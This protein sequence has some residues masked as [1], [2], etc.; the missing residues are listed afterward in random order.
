MIQ[1]PLGVE[2][3]MMDKVRRDEVQAAHVWIQSFRLSFSLSM[4]VYV[5]FVK[6]RLPGHTSFGWAGL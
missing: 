1:D 4:K 5:K 6:G 2:G 3:D